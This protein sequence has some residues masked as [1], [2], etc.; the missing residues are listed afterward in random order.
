MSSNFATGNQWYLNGVV[1]NGATGQ[2]F[3][4]TQSGNYRVDVTL[5]NGC[6]SQSDNFTYAILSINPTT[7]PFGLAVFPVPANSQLN[8]V[9]A[10]PAAADLTL[11]IVNSIG[12][13][14]YSQSQ[15]IPVGNFSTQ[16]DVS[17]LAAGS[18]LLKVQLGEKAYTRKVVIER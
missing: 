13:N 10:A 11:S 2:T 1:I 17:H 16:I 5:A 18:Y 12:Q 9:F 3:S 7:T 6:V 14:A 8:V 15:T 4:P